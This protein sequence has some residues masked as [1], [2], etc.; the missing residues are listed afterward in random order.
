M[1]SG[2]MTTRRPTNP[3]RDVLSDPLRFAERQIVQFVLATLSSSYFHPRFRLIIFLQYLL[4]KQR[5]IDAPGGL[6]ATFFLWG[7][8][9]NILAESFVEKTESFFAMAVG[10][11]GVVLHG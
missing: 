2:F 9:E 5:G 3:F 1:K 4:H 6:L 8:R 7:C 11:K 10:G